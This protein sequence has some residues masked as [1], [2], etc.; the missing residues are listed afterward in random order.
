[1][2]FAGQEPDHVQ[3]DF[4]AQACCW[5]LKLFEKKEKVL[6]ITLSTLH[7]GIAQYVTD[8]CLS[9]L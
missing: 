9:V 2:E 6:V 4:T 7:S 5:P 8:T 1:M 3:I